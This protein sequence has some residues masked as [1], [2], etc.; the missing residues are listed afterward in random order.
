MQT[1]QDYNPYQM[2]QDDFDEY[3]DDIPPLYNPNAAALWS[4]LFMPFGAWIHAKNWE[5][6]G[7]YDLAKQNY[8][9][10]VGSVAFF[11]INTLFDMTMGIAFPMAIN[12]G[13]LVGWYVALGKKQ[14]TAFKE[15]LGTDYEKKSLFTPV[16][17]GVLGSNV[18][19]FIIIMALQILLSMM[20]LLHPSW[21]E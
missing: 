8:W 16:L 7:E 12:V 14:I 15:E 4:L 10:A 19:L 5:A 6:V 9:V 2:P 17:V 20:G 21:L 3:H 11:L 18:A 13:L 1:S